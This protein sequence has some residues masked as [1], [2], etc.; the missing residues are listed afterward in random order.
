MF[1][2]ERTWSRREPLQVSCYNLLRETAL[3]QFERCIASV[4]MSW[5]FSCA[6]QVISE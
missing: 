4:R 5:V 6:I 3:G 1:V 2:A